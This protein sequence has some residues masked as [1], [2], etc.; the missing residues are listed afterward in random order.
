MQL[1]RRNKVNKNAA[2]RGLSHALGTDWLK[3]VGSDWLKYTDWNIFLR[4]ASKEIHHA[5]GG[6]LDEF[7]AQY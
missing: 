4:R 5:L 3:S 2:G 1:I 7:G 6:E